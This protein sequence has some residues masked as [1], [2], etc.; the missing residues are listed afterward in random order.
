MVALLSAYVDVRGTGSVALR[1]TQDGRY[2]VSLSGSLTTIVDRAALARSSVKVH[3]AGDA[4][5]LR[6]SRQ[7][8]ALVLVQNAQPRGERTRIR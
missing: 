1:P 5:A 7:Q 4:G 8:G 3:Y 6:M 2:E